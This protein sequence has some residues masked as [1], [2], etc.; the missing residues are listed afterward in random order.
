M[1][2]HPEVDPPLE[3]DIDGI[4]IYGSQNKPA[5]QAVVPATSPPEKKNKPLEQD[6]LDAPVLEGAR[7]KRLCC[8]FSYGGGIRE[9]EREKCIFHPGVPIFHE[10]LPIT[11]VINYFRH[12]MGCRGN[13]VNKRGFAKLILENRIKRLFL[14]QEARLRVRPIP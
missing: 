6:D 11:V 10:G 14:L 3:R 4:E 2:K 12:H 1:Q 13:G 5:P 9:G 8:D 7:C